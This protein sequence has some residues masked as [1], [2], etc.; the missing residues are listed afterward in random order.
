MLKRGRVFVKSKLK[1][2]VVSWTNVSQPGVLGPLR[3]RRELS[4]GPRD[5][6]GKLVLNYLVK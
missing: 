4:G 2:T 1:V 3:G 6:R 5:G